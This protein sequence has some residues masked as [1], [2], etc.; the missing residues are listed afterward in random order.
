MSNSLFLVEYAQASDGKLLE[1]TACVIQQ[2]FIDQR[3]LQQIE[4]D[5]GFNTTPIF[6]EAGSDELIEIKHLDDDKIHEIYDYFCDAFKKLIVKANEKLNSFSQGNAITTHT[7][8]H[9]NE[10][11]FND[12]EQFRVLANLIAILKIKIEQYNGAKTVFL[13]V[14]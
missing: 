12:V 4:N 8:N 1:D 13:K 11:N 5:W 9:V 14:G 10:F 7:N 3:L 6:E 2:A